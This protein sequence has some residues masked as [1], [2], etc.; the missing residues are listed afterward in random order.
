MQDKRMDMAANISVLLT[1]L[2]RTLANDQSHKRPTTPWE[3]ELHSCFILLWHYFH[4]PNVKTAP[5]RTPLPFDLVFSAGPIF[6]RQ[7]V[8][9]LYILAVIIPTVFF[10]NQI[11]LLVVV[12]LA[13][14]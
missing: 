14:K 7:P 10:Q 4:R 2:Y 9:L 1:F 12:F 6:L 3:Q 11:F 13:K 5:Q 8:S